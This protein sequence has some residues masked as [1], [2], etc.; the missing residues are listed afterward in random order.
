MVTIIRRGRP[1]FV[2]QMR[3]GELNRDQCSPKFLSHNFPPDMVVNVKVL[4]TGEIDLRGKRN[5]YR[6]ILADKI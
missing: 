6:I 2:K 3:V 1:L 5:E 4:I